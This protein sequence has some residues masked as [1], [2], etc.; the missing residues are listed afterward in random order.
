M[1]TAP[2]IDASV[3]RASRTDALV[4]ISGCSARI[5][6]TEVCW[7]ELTHVRSIAPAS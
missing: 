5:V 1:A 6:S 2:T 3:Q 4:A 7:N